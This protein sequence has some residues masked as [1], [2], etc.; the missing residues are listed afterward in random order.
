VVSAQEAAVY[1]LKHL[2]ASSTENTQ[3]DPSKLGTNVDK[4]V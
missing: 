2:S 4:L 3:T 1:A